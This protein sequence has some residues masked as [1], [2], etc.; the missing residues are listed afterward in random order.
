[1]YP[2][3][4]SVQLI[5]ACIMRWERHCRRMHDSL[6]TLGLPDADYLTIKKS[7]LQQ[8]TSGIQKARIL[9]DGDGFSIDLFTYHIRPLRQLHLITDNNISYTLKYTDR[10]CF[11][12][13]T[14]GLTSEEDVL[15]VKEGKITDTSFSNIALLQDGIW[16][17]PSTPLLKGTR[18]AEL[19]ESGLIQERE[20]WMT[21]LNKYTQLSCINAMLN[22]GDLCVKPPEYKP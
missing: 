10:S 17:T 4:E 7:I 3:F 21:E 6:Q 22:I 1:M 2:L 14:R 18:R 13:Y 8:A 5:D 12:K 9:Y 15:F 20:I 11:E 16:Y 19:V